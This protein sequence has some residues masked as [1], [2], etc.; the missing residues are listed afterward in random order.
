MA[1]AAIMSVGEIS[2]ISM[3]LLQTA[4]GANCIPCPRCQQSLCHLRPH[5]NGD[6]GGN[7]NSHA[8]GGDSHDGNGGSG[9]GVGNSRGSGHD[10]VK[11][12]VSNIR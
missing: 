6:N 4:S 12:S 5:G 10:T 7:G 9:N 8:H 1:I 3:E 11:N 2:F